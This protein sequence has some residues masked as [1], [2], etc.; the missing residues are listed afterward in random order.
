MA[1]TPEDLGRSLIGGEKTRETEDP[2][3][4]RAALE[5]MR[6]ADPHQVSTLEELARLARREGRWQDAA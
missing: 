6:E 5:A 1:V 3:A 4:R 2:A